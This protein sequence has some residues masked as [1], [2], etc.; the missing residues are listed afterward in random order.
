MA[1]FGSL[2]LAPL[3]C[4]YSVSAVTFSRRE[5]SPLSILS[6]KHFDIGLFTL[7]C[8][9]FDEISGIVGGRKCATRTEVKQFVENTARNGNN[10]FLG[11]VEMEVEG[12]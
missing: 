4:L 8:F 9:E 12:A 3:Q 10:P 5:L 11:S 1:P 7:E 6:H 2:T